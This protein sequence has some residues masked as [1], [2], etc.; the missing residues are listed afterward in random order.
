MY[1]IFAWQLQNT[2]PE[3]CRDVLV[4]S[5]QSLGCRCIFGIGRLKNSCNSLKKKRAL[6]IVKGLEFRKSDH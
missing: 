3:V 1:K 6:I 2:G 5:N 4:I